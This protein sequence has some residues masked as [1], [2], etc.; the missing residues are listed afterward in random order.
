METM[1][2]M[3]TKLCLDCNKD[4]NLSCFHKDKN[5]KDGLYVY[6]KE[7]VSKQSSDY[8][9]RNKEKLNLKNKENHLKNRDRNLAKQK[10]YNQ[11][12]K[13]EK[14]ERDRKH[15]EDNPGL[16]AKK[17]KKYQQE[18]KD[19]INAKKRVYIKQK[20]EKDPAYKLARRLRSRLCKFVTGKLKAGSFVKDMGCSIVELKK[21]LE[22]LFYCHPAT[23]EKMSWDN[24]GKGPGKWQIDHMEALCLFDLL[25]REQF[26]KACHYTNLQP[27]WH[28]DHAIKTELDILKKDARAA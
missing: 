3:E 9:S 12:H 24:Y 21:Y 1:S 22:S 4:V 26:L 19:K 11:A 16:N 10:L 15:R 27:L 14:A 8:R 6:C 23:L 17:C 18:N 7:C 2:N 20:C 13:K 5:R 25:D 28:D